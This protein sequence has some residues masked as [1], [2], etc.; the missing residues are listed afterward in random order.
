MS[1]SPSLPELGCIVEV[2]SGR[3]KGSLCVVVGY[4]GDRFVLMADGDKRKADS[5]KRK[6]VSHVRTTPYLA[7]GV[8]DDL[9]T[10]GKVTNARLRYVLRQHRDE[11]READGAVE[12]GGLPNGE[13]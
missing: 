2:T 7:H 12:E 3:D 11:R 9:R 1:K 8:L 10:H 5:P 13:G 6:N 4:E